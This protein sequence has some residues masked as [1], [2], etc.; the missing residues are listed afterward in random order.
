MRRTRWPAALV[1]LLAIALA[2]ALPAG[3]QAKAKLYKFKIAGKM[4]MDWQWPV[5]QFNRGQRD[6]SAFDLLGG[7]GCGSK[8]THARWKVKLQ[9]EGIPVQ[10]LIIDFVFGGAKNPAKVTDA[11]Y[12]GTPQ[13]DMQ[14][15]LK[16]G[17]L[18]AMNVKLIGKPTGDII[19]PNINP[20]TAKLTKK[21]VKK[22]PIT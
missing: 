9:N 17:S 21:R 2:G 19:G 10:S 18:K 11:N 5:N 15:Y 1:A 4:H 14:I 22:C 12:A 7:S 13:A 3:A 20:G 8:P 6:T 16:F